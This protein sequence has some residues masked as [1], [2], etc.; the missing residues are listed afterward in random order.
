MAAA[1]GRPL[2]MD[3]AFRNGT[4]FDVR[5]GRAAGRPFGEAARRRVRVRPAPAAE[6]S[7]GEVVVGAS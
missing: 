2:A 3:R 1:A 7:A 4:R 5:S 6:E